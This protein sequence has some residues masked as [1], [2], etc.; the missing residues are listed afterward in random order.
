MYGELG[1]AL[2]AF[3]RRMTYRKLIQACELRYSVI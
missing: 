1:Y 2:V 3:C